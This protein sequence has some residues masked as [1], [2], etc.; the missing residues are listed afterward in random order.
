MLRSKAFSIAAHKRW[1]K[2]IKIWTIRICCRYQ[3]CDS[4]RL[5]V[6]FLLHF[7][8]LYV[9]CFLY[10][11]QN[12]NSPLRCSIEK[13]V[14]EN[15]AKFTG[16]HLYQSLFLNEVAGLVLANLLKKR[17][18]GL[19]FYLKHKLMHRLSPVNFAKFSRAPFSTEHIWW[20]L[21][22]KSYPML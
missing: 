22:N 16:K 10:C 7:Q 21:L 1:P 18:L 13:G 15:F 9:L 8:L 19:R 2:L 3:W 5:F 14:L 17:L 20:L 11:Q 12:R 4:P 6:S